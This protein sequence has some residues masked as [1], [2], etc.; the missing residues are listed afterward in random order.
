MVGETAFPAAGWNDFI[1]V[2]IGWWARA[3]LQLLRGTSKR[4]EVH[5]MDG[6]Y[7]VE[8]VKRS[9]SEW[10]IRLFETGGAKRLRSQETIDATLL[11]DSIVAASQSVLAACR[12]H[13]LW[14]VDADALAD[15][16]LAL[17]KESI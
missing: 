10:D 2:V 1:V 11:V 12:E 3:V 7:L 5:F 16:E 8:L 14:S 15:Q 9:S 4:E 13:N 17:R 6:A